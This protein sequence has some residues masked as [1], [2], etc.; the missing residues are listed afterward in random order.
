MTLQ[1]YWTVRDFYTLGETF[2]YVALVQKADKKSKTLKFDIGNH[3]HNCMSPYGHVQDLYWSSVSR[4]P[5]SPR[6]GDRVVSLSPHYVRTYVALSLH[7]M[8]RVLSGRERERLRGYTATASGVSLATL[9]TY[10]A[11]CRATGYTGGSLFP[12]HT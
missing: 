7:S 11:G 9:C 8:W 4:L 12:L 1:R 6:H 2:A 5:S 3:L 10:V